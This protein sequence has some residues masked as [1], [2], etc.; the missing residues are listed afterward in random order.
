MKKI[1]KVSLNLFT[2]ILVLTVFFSSIKEQQIIKS[3]MII[4]NLNFLFP[5]GWGF[6][7]RNPR[8]ENVFFYKIDSNNK[9]KEFNLLNQS[10]GNLFGFSRYTRLLSFDI[11]ILTEMI[12]EKKWYSSNVVSESI[13]LDIKPIKIKASSNLQYLR[14]GTYII[15]LQKTVPWSWS[16]S[17]QSK[18][19]P[20]KIVKIQ[21]HE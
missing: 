11:A 10:S 1:V 21:I 6:F 16:N 7:T 3:P 14:K 15:K 2:I 17:N 5:Q 9:I 12:N 18:Y 20:F 8:E 19:S 4:K 13:Y